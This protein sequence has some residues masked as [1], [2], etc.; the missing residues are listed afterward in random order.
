MNANIP[1]K[2]IVAAA[3]LIPA[4]G[5]CSSNTPTATDPQ[6]CLDLARQDN[7]EQVLKLQL[8]FESLHRLDSKS[9]T[10]QEESEAVLLMKLG[11]TEANWEDFSDQDRSCLAVAV[12]DLATSSTR[13]RDVIATLGNTEL[14]QAVQAIHTSRVSPPTTTR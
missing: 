4:A 2:I 10:E 9:A 11:E 8:S 12:D 6:E 7:N 14:A 3:L 1:R 5:A 13:A